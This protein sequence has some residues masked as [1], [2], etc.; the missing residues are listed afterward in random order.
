MPNSS[1]K[2]S[3]VIPT[4]NEEKYIASC[5]STALN[6]SKNIPEIIVV[7]AGSND[8]T[9]D[10]LKE[11]QDIKV[12]SDESLKGLKYASLNRGAA[13]ASGNVLLFLDADTI[14]PPFYD[15]LIFDA[16]KNGY[17]AGAFSLKFDEVNLLLQLI[18][19]MNSF[20]YRITKRFFG[21]QAIFCSVDL[22]KKVKGF[23]EIRI[24]EAAHLC[25]KLKTIAKLKLLPQEVITSN[26]RFKGQGVLN[27]FIADMKILIKDIFN[28]NLS[29]EGEAYWNHI[30]R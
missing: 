23:P 24:M 18:S 17:Q 8:A 22:F 28:M 30:D 15:E 6:N 11:L 7:D 10:I 25:Q 9:I 3:I 5:I 19:L 2:L 14:L 1:F 21:D 20:R 29:K 13:E 4:L 12:I 16:F 27:V 26:R